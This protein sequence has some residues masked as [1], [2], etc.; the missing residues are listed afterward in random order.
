[1]SAKQLRPDLLSEHPH[2][3]FPSAEDGGGRPSLTLDL[4]LGTEVTNPNRIS[5]C[6][7]RPGPSLI[8]L[9]DENMSY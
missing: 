3:L 7:H 4:D 8:L 5:M 1:M 2:C 9:P 6:S